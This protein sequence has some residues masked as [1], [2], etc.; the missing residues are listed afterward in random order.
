[1]YP[2]QDVSLSPVLWEY[3]NLNNVFACYLEHDMDGGTVPTLMIVVIN[4]KD[5]PTSILLFRFI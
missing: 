5:L 4:W 3:K 2:L 1:M